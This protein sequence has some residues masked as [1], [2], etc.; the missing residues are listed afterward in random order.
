MNSNVGIVPFF[1][2]GDIGG[3]TYLVTNNIVNYLI[4]I[5]TLSGV[6]KW[7][8]KV[9]F[10]YVI[11]GMSIG[12]FLGCCYYAWM[13][14]RISKRDQRPDVTALPSGVSTTAMFVMLYGVIMPLSYAVEDPMVAWSAAM[15]ACFLG[16]VIEFVGGIVGPWMK[17][18]IPRA[19][20]LGT[21]AGIG[22]IWMA[23]EGVFDIFQDPILG[24]PVMIV[25]MLGV[26]GVYA[27]PEKDPASCSGDRWRHRVCVLS[28]TD[29]SGFQ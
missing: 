25:A 9:V 11:P 20:L 14:Y 19:A 2:R 5:A 28:G 1:K 24:L 15:A 29:P 23:T 13:G 16:G 3:L 7:P 17:K 10:G 18:R 4:V 27:F 8:D 26:F 12:L 6:L 21:V 22:F